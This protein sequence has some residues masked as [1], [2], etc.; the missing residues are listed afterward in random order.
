MNNLCQRCETFVNCELDC[1][2][3]PK[4]AEFVINELKEEYDDLELPMNNHPSKIDEQVEEGIIEKELIKKKYYTPAVYNAI[5]RYREKFPEKYN[6]AQ[7]NLYNRKKNDEEWLKKF[8][9]RSREYNK[10]YREK[11]KEE[12]KLLGIVPKKGRPRKVV[13]VSKNPIVDILSN[14]EGVVI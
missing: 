7:R 10:K 6:E 5:K 2:Y 12:N 1:G 11:K 3:C 8:N 4:C 13:E 14:V 9:E